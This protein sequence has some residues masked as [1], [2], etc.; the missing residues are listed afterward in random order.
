M[1]TPKYKNYNL[2]ICKEQ[3]N[4]QGQPLLKI[5]RKFNQFVYKLVLVCS[6]LLI[7]NISSKGDKYE[8]N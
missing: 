1:P 7:Y 2:L 6:F 5:V 3:Q 8:G 4:G